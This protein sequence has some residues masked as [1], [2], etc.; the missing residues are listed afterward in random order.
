MCSAS[1][2]LAKIFNM[3][4]YRTEWREVMPQGMLNNSP[5][6][7]VAPL[8]PGRS[9]RRRVSRALLLP[10]VVASLVLSGQ[11]AAAD[12]PVAPPE[13]PT[14]LR[15]TTGE[16][17]SVT[18]AWT[19]VDWGGF[20]PGTLAPGREFPTRRP[21]HRHR[22]HHHLHGLD[23]RQTG[24]SASKP[25]TQPAA[26]EGPTPPSSWGCRSDRPACG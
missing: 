18:A 12:R 24:L 6:M 8:R 1:F 10:L 7:F 21:A 26:A 23:R 5:W 4:H 20:L 15:L 19:A 11:A 14:G 3:R 9:A 25:A 2:A 16:G 17:R 22:R 13:R